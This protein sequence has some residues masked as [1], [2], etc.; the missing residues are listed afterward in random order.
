MR[1]IAD[2][3]GYVKEVSFGA[4]IVCDGQVCTEYVGAVPTG[5]ASLEA[6]FIEEI[7]K[8]YRWKVE[9]L[10]VAGGK[11]RFGFSAATLAYRSYVLVPTINSD[12][13]VTLTNNLATAGSYYRYVRYKVNETFAPGT[14]LTGSA[15]FEYGRESLTPAFYYRF[16]LNGEKV[17]SG[18][19]CSESGPKT[20]TVPEHDTFYLEFYMH[21][22]AAYPDDSVV[23]DTVTVSNIQLEVGDA[24][25]EYEAFKER[26]D[27]TLDST[28]VAPHDKTPE[29]ILASMG[30]ADYI[31]EEDTSGSWDY[32]KWKSGK[33]EAWRHISAS[34]LTH[35][36][37]VL[38]W[39]YRGITYEFPTGLFTEVTE[40]FANGK[41]G[42]GLSHATA[43]DYSS[44]VVSVYF[45]ASSTGDMHGS[46]YAVGK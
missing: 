26:K 2:S 27:L 14:K 42:S 11:N 37:T 40:C 43:R 23:G 36:G 29:E 39:Y 35:T 24:V 1:Y 46:I 20:F 28:A 32:R 44:D 34:G 3:D 12:N 5:Y 31:V 30:V 38:S 13:S 7:E 9:S 25:T 33:I 21:I 41:W 4:D 8:L 19:A 17:S 6:W 10:G 18:Y 45:L 16:M 22:Y 15:D